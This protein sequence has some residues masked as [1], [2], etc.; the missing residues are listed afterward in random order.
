MSTM[1]E[2]PVRQQILFEVWGP[3]LE[4]N[5]LAFFARVLQ[6]IS[7]CLIC[8]K[9]SICCSGW[10]KACLLHLSSPSVCWISIWTHTLHKNSQFWVARTLSSLLNDL[11]VEQMLAGLLWPRAFLTHT[12]TVSILCYTLHVI[13]VE[14]KSQAGTKQPSLP[15]GFLLG[16]GSLNVADVFQTTRG[17]TVACLL[18]L[19]L[20]SQQNTHNNGSLRMLSLENIWYKDTDVL[21]RRPLGGLSGHF[22]PQEH[23]CR[24]E[25]RWW[26][27]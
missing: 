13:V 12:E 22:T 4:R 15:P 27:T 19:L 11:T 21:K 3:D 14:R 18:I 24:S 2:V 16:G 7:K 25:G 20:A 6:N 23:S 10:H 17:Q 5:P 1:A 9:N 8:L 26:V